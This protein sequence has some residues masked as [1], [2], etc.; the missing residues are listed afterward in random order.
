MTCQ[1]A[2]DLFSAY[3][4]G[5]LTGRQCAAVGTH[6][7]GCAS[8]REE[9]ETLRNAI[10]MLEAPKAM[11][12]PEGLLEEFKTKY[13][14]EA[15]AAAAAPRWGFKLPVLP[16]VEWPSMGRVLLP[17]GGMAAAAA[18]L[19]V[20]LHNNPA[21]VPVAV[22]HQPTRV[23]SVDIRSGDVTMKKESV[24]PVS[25]GSVAPA[26]S[27]ARRNALLDEARAD[28]PPTA[29]PVVRREVA[30]S[31]EPTARTRRRSVVIAEVPQPERRLVRGSPGPRLK[32]NVQYAAGT[33]GA[34]ALTDAELKGAI[35]YA[36]ATPSP[37]DQ[38]KDVVVVIH[39]KTPAA[40]EEEGFAA[41]SCRNLKT[42]EVKSATIGTPTVAA[43]GEPAPEVSA[44]AAAATPAP[45]TGT[46]DNQ[47]PAEADGK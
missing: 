18:A 7:G 36:E 22:N 15:E 38:W 46:S 45:V 17:M 9:L 11:A 2:G 21:G 24:T 3:I 41:V 35:D 1:K 12:R 29:P 10:A 26:E 13:L 47:S 28:G 4:D 27:K 44:P 40:S 5:E 23:A 16:K 32:A 31:P 30:A 37:E 39:R 19:L 20:S 42:G 14:P 34:S 6:L 8:C 43:T 25:P 33:L